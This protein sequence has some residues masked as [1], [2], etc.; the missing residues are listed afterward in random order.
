MDKQKG[1]TLIE[2]L[3]ETGYQTSGAT[4]PGSGIYATWRHVGRNLHYTAT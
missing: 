1:I 4:V 3:K 2:M